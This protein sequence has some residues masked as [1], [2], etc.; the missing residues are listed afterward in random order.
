RPHASGQPARDGAPCANS[1][2]PR[3]STRC[4]GPLAKCAANTLPRPLGTMC[5]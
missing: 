2:L 5:S 4:L 1:L 3:P